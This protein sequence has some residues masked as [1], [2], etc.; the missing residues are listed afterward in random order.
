MGGLLFVVSIIARFMQTELFFI[1]LGKYPKG[2]LRTSKFKTLKGYFSLV[3]LKIIIIATGIFT[4]YLIL[5]SVD[6]LN[7]T[8]PSISL[9][10]NIIYFLATCFLVSGIFL[11]TKVKFDF[12]EKHKMTKS[13]IIQEMKE[14]EGSQETK[15]II[16]SM[17]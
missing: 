13:E 2:T 12:I 10:H 6:L 4:V 11:I 7:P 8:P 1:P 17:N 15:K 3:F 16:R 9:I 5:N 14:T